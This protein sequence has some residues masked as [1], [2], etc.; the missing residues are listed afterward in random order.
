MT[1][2]KR[3]MCVLSV[4]FLVTTAVAEYRIFFTAAREGY[5]LTK[6]FY[7]AGHPQAGEPWLIDNPSTAITSD[8]YIPD[9]SNNTD[10]YSGDYVLTAG[11]CYMT[12]G[13][14]LQDCDNPAVGDEW[15]YIWGQFF[16]E[17]T[18]DVLHSASMCLVDCAT[19]EEATNL[20]AF[21]YKVD[22]MAPPLGV[23][24]WDGGS[25]EADNY[26]TFRNTCQS[27]VAVSAY[28]IKNQGGT[29]GSNWNLYTGGPQDGDSGRVSLLG[30]VRIPPGEDAGPYTLEVPLDANG[31]PYFVIS[32]V[33][34]MP[35]V[36]G[37]MADGG[38]ACCFPD[39]SCSELSPVDCYNAGGQYQGPGTDCTPNP[40]DDDPCAT[41]GPG[42]HWIDT[43]MSGEDFMPSSALVGIDFD[44][45]GLADTSLT[46]N[47]MV[48]IRRSGAL[49]VSMHYPDVAIA[50]G[51]RDVIDTEITQME[52]FGAGVTLIAGAEFGAYPLSASL[53]AI[54]EQPGNPALGD[55][56]FEVFFEIDLGGGQLAYN[57]TALNVATVIDCI[58]PDATYLHPVGVIPLYSDPVGGVWVA[59]LVT[60]NHDTYPT[61]EACCLPDGT[62]IDVDPNDCE[63]QDGV[64]QGP[65]TVCTAEEACCLPDQDC[66]M[67]D[68]LCCE[69]IDGVPQG[70]GSACT[71]VEACCMPP[72]YSSCLMIDPAC[73]L[74][75]GGIPAGS[76]TCDPNPCV[77]ACCSPEGVCSVLTQA[78]CASAGG[79]YQGDGTTCEPD[80]CLSGACC[81]ELG[82][83]LTADWWCAVLCGVFQGAGTTCDP[84]PCPPGPAP[85]G[86]CC[87]PDNSCTVITREQC[88]LAFGTYLGDESGCTPWPC[89]AACCISIR[90]CRIITPQECDAL[91]G[92]FLGPMSDCP[93][94]TVRFAD[95]TG[96]VATHITITVINCPPPALVRR[97]DDCEPGPPFFDPWVSPDESPR[98]E[99][100][101]H[102]F[103]A[104]DQAVP[105]G[106]FFSEGELE[107]EPFTDNVC[108]RGDPLEP[109][110]PF[111][112]ADTLI[113]RWEEPFDRCTPPTPVPETVSIELVELNLVSLEPIKVQ[114][115]TDP[116]DCDGNGEVDVDEINANGGSGGVGGLLDQN[117][118]GNLDV[119]EWDVV[120][121][122]SE[123][124][125]PEGFLTAEKTHC[126]GGT[127]F[128]SLNVQPQFLFT[129]V[130]DGAEL[131]L[132]TGVYGI[133]YITIDIPAEE[134]LDWV[135]H[136]DPGFVI[137]NPICTDFHPGIAD[138]DP[139]KWDYNSNDILDDCDI[140]HG[141]SQDCNTNGV[142]DECDIAVGT[143]MDCNTNGVPDECEAGV[144]DITM[145]GGFVG[146]IFELDPPY[147]LGSGSP[148]PETMR[149]GDYP[150][151]GSMDYWRQYDTFHNGDQGDEDW[152]GYEFSYAR[153]FH[154]LIFQE[155]MHFVDGGWFD[156]FQVQV[157]SDGDW[158][159]VANLNSDP[160]YPGN[161]GVNFETFTLTFEPLAGDAIR[162]YG[163]P[164]GEANFIGFGEYRVL[165][166]LHPTFDC[167]TNGVL[168]E[169]DIA[170]GT[171][172]DANG[173][174]I[175]DECEVCRG[176]SNCDGAINWRD[177]DYFVAAMN[178]NVAAWEAMFAPGTPSCSF[179]NND[180]N[181]DGTV[182]WRD[183][184]PFVALMNTT[185]P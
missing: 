136:V 172:Q 140:E 29:G 181:E 155:G 59:N 55:S 162:L 161:N 6:G 168:D 171:S 132:D 100:T 107:S 89:P 106:F 95:D 23:R 126:N 21:W 39:H 20:E 119:C 63:Q 87:L 173:N 57:H 81:L 12:G 142:P 27:L 141:T 68:P 22:N 129:N 91:G 70:A 178:D 61:P 182:N 104:E 185:C 164:G 170:A 84:D 38:G 72:D 124:A 174:G 113:R 88:C 53:G 117:E 167:N 83:V 18:G 28:G 127:F 92:S 58:V 184:D 150:P 153:E 176:D 24:R 99:A 145:A 149:N 49:D 1:T 125:P 109:G 46:L 77:G 93:T 148:N 169:C 76:A 120:V 179:E 157:R 16:G 13:Y 9:Y 78:A 69:E 118:N 31:D 116:S 79:D 110:G 108:F 156:A 138:E 48:T 3:L 40:C 19:G 86:G 135:H 74:F 96:P 151:V 166:M 43:C 17:D 85:T 37:F 11:P 45:D 180:A 10:V 44:G 131:I 42:A 133:P 123:V 54:V 115:G 97:D 147:P 152:M 111:G 15:F 26:S 41:C 160:P 51:H 32:N 71:A 101:C 159:D 64:P 98:G 7:P 66:L 90:D 60:A 73:C 105:A 25:T 139:T 144:G 75:F 5:G 65:E 52:L 154:S 134:P 82:C 8:D 50:D 33:P 35:F 143:S 121:G 47:G 165:A 158:T 94:Q 128:T 103:G 4:C 175:P 67:L 130:A 2:M 56:A 137:V 114:I 30:A 62:C 14:N 36:G 146:K 112:D 163:D 34:T 80:P 122:L 177:I 102:N 183:I